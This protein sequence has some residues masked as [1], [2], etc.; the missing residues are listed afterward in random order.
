MRT[1]LIHVG[2]LCVGTCGLAAAETPAGANLIPNGGFE[3]VR[4][5]KVDARGMI[6]KWRV[7][8][9]PVLPR[10][11]GLS[12]T[13][14]GEIT[15][16][17]DPTA[18]AFEGR[19][20]IRL[21]S[22]Q[23]KLHLI[24]Q[25]VSKVSAGT[26]YEVS[27]RVRGGKLSVVLFP[28]GAGKPLGET[29]VAA[30]AGGDGRWRRVAGVY[31]PPHGCDSV[32]MVLR[33]GPGQ[34]VD[35]DDVRL[36]EV[37]TNQEGSNVGEPI[38]LENK[39]VKMTIRGDGTLA[40]LVDKATGRDY[41]VPEARPMFSLVWGGV[42]LLPQSV[43]LKEDILTIAYPD[44]GI[45]VQLKVAQR[46]HYFTFDVVS[47]KE[48]LV[49]RA[50]KPVSDRV[51]QVSIVELPVRMTK[52]R[53]GHMNAC[54][55]DEFA[56]AVMALS[57]RVSA[58]LRTL[59]SAGT[60]LVARAHRRFGLVGSR[61]AVI[62]CAQ[63]ELTSVIREMEAAEGLAC[64]M[65]KGQW[66][67]ESELVKQSYFF[68]VDLGE[69]NADDT[70]RY[71]K[72]GG[73]GAILI[74]MNW[75]KSAGHWE[76]SPVNFPHGRDGLKQVVA[77]MH[78]AG[79]RAGLHVDAK[80]SRDDPYATP[81]PDPR[82]AGIQSA[83]L[84]QPID[85]KAARFV[86]TRVPELCPRWR[87]PFAYSSRPLNIV[88]IGDELIAF[89]KLHEQRPFGFSACQ[90][91]YNDTTPAA[92]PAGARVKHVY[93]MNRGFVIDPDTTL[94]D[95]AADH[96]ARVFNYCDLD[97]IYFDEHAVHDTPWYTQGM[98]QWAFYSRIKR[99][100][101]LAQGAWG[102]SNHN[103]HFLV[104]T[105]MA[106]GNPNM[107]EDVEKRV[108]TIPG[109]RKT[110]V[111]SSI[112]WYRLHADT[113]PDAIE[114]I[115]ARSAGYD[116]SIA[117]STGVSSVAKNP[118]G[119]YILRAVNRYETCRLGGV[120]PDKVRAMLRRPGHEFKLFGNATAGWK[121]F[122][123][124]Y[125]PVRHVTLSD[126]TSRAWTVANP[127]KRP[128]P[129]AVHLSR[130]RDRARRH[131]GPGYGDPG[132]IVLAD[133]DTDADAF[134][135]DERSPSAVR[136]S[137]TAGVTQELSFSSEDVHEGRRCAVW[138][139]TNAEDGR[140]GANTGK[141]I[142]PPLNI[143]AHKGTGL[144]VHGDG[145]GER[146]RVQ[147]WDAAGKWQNFFVT[148]NYTGWRYWEFRRPTKD[149]IDYT[150][151]SYLRLYY[152]GIPAKGKVQCRFDDIKAITRLTGAES[153]ASPSISVGDQSIT[154]PTKLGA[155]QVLVYDGPG[156]C[157]LFGP[158]HPNGK[159]VTPAG[160]GPVLKPGN[161]R[162]VVS[163]DRIPGPVDVSVRLLSL[164][165]VYP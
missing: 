105:E 39:H 103:W 76:V 118:L 42:T 77:K 2:V 78:A 80:V 60:V 93:G 102:T 164:E 62:A 19:R 120:F 154:F 125:E 21:T 43:R 134:A 26:R 84:A 101:I 70:I 138:T 130:T 63:R 53:A 100:D 5:V 158:R 156:G 75:R 140:G 116:A 61:A 104:R 22:G 35:V 69:A 162:I 13:C 68:A 37:V 126:G 150:Q 141:R 40:A 7:R 149:R 45:E 98:I 58:G 107:K 18:P 31:I 163:C 127:C 65:Y 32:M 117:V 3:Q 147:L 15:V 14:V 85:A 82:L 152:I 146:I 64:P 92:H 115:A 27:A 121:L 155:G 50:W 123:A 29:V 109:R 51:E 74:L 17:P 139:A 113:P 79:L 124:R 96:F 66:L 122:R 95:E 99:K 34:H 38:V 112:G 137:V 47:V 131:A 72:M 142:H 110:M 55:D 88:Q 89:G 132:V 143:S 161:N 73:F 135:K 144:W 145:R 81:I 165:A 91:G 1:D 153:L 6:A 30:G 25:G 41:R 114:L 71:A 67:R 129:I 54:W 33:V 97:M 44:D 56:A 52:A 20:C 16:Q 36:A 133:F 111:A 148:V 87:K 46:E 94:L 11:W 151:V 28:K 86:T 157:K 10:A 159:P 106:D 119:D 23:E 24:Q 90:R 48:D 4:P 160:A 59:G 9:E 8:G 49:E 136:W 128:L 12:S 83:V 57:V 108:R